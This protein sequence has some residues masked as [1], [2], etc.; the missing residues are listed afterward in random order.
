MGKTTKEKERKFEDGRPCKLTE[1]FKDKFVALVQRGNHLVSVCKFLRV[2]FST[3]RRWMRQAKTECCKCEKQC[4]P[5]ER[6]N[7]T[8]FCQFYQ[9]VQEAIGMAEISVVSAWQETLNVNSP[10]FDYRSCRDF[11]ARR[12][13]KRWANRDYLKNEHRLRFDVKQLTDEQLRDVVEGKMPSGIGTSK[14]TDETEEEL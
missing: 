5:E 1:T 13:P 10:H 12:Y 6:K 7:C 8:L 3:Y 4:L 14:Q 11:L 2:D 9:E